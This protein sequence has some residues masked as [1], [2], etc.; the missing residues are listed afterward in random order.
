VVVRAG[1]QTKT[2]YPMGKYAVFIAQGYKRGSG[3]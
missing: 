2:L 1:W 3:F